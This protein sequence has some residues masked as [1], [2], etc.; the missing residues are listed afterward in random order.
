MAYI[1]FDDNGRIVE[2]DH[3][4]NIL[5]GRAVGPLGAP[6]QSLVVAPD[7]QNLMWSTPA[8]SGTVIGTGS[9]GQVAYWNA[10][11]SITGTAGFT[12]D[13]TNLTMSGGL[14]V[15]SATGAAAGQTI[16][17][18]TDAGTTT[19][20]NVLNIQHRSSGTPAANF[21][22]TFILRAE[23]DNHTMAAIANQTAIWVVA[24]N[25]AQ[26]GRSSFNVFDT[27]SREAWRMEASGS[28]AMIGFLGAAAIVRPSST[29]DLRVALINLGL[30]TTGGA[31]PLDL[32]GGALTAGTGT[33][34]GSVVV[35]LTSGSASA[36]ATVNFRDTTTN[37]Q[38]SG[39][40]V[41][42]L[43]TATPIAGFG[44][45]ITYQLDTSTNALVAAAS[46]KV[47]WTD[48]ANATYKPQMTILMR[49]SGGARE[50]ARFEADGTV[51][52]IGFYGATAI[53]K[54]SSTTD[55]RVALINLGLYT[56]GGATP[57][58]LNGGAFT[59]TGAATVNSLT[60]TTTI[61]S[62]DGVSTVGNGVPSLVATVDLT[63]QAASIGTTTLYAVPAAGVG[64]YRLNW[65]IKVTKAATSS[66]TVGPMTFT[67]V[68][69][70]GITVTTTAVGFTQAG[71]AATSN[72]VNTTQGT[73]AGSQLVWAKAST[74]ITYAFTYASSG[75]T[76][77]TYD[78][79][80]KVECLG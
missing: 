3:P 22:V 49:D 42:H 80:I 25:G 44:T 74:N 32:N 77:M 73:L 72:S 31:T 46:I 4:L 35:G 62:Y 59:T 28:A 20:P 6:G 26:T 19:S 8:G 53:V 40:L 15:G 61:T 39:L 66:S 76:A 79:H 45:Q 24:T 51:A 36:T 57:L 63:V 2:T 48:S 78:I 55:L 13:G 70:A 16:T 33:F 68:D 30:Y 9:A 58:D 56:T 52:R 17:E 67:H 11:S 21:D 37:T 18:I 50:A 47:Q 23:T 14:N 71:A 60:V 54:P 10:S 29:T 34:S 41:G 64:L 75:V 1:I 43:T 5:S 38:P 65:Y 27:A 7:G 12:F 69:A